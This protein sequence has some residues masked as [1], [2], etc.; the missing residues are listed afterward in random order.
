[1]GLMSWL[2]PSEAD[3]IAKAQ[4]MLDKRRWAGARAEVLDIDDPAAREIVA[5]AEHELALKNL[6]AAVAHCRSG[7]DDRARIHLK[8]ATEFAK[9]AHEEA[10]REAR[11][12]MRSIREG[13]RA[14]EEMRQ[15]SEAEMLL[16]VHPD[17]VSDDA[18]LQLPPGVSD[19]Q[20]E[21]LYARLSLIVDNYPKKLRK[22]MAELG[23]D[24]AQ[25]VLDLEDGKLDAALKVLL[26]LPDD[27]ALVRYERARAAHAMGD[28]AAAARA[29][30]GFEAIAGHHT[31]GR[32]HTG[33]LL[34][35]VLAES[36]KV[37]EAL[38]TL[39]RVRRKDRDAGGVLF[40]QL[41][42][43]RDRLPE[44]E[45]VLA[46]LVRKHPSE[47]PLY[48]LLARVRR[49]GGH[50]MAA[51][52]ALETGL[53]QSNCTPGRCG[54]KP[55]DLAAHR[56][57]ATLYLEDGIETERALELAGIAASLVKQQTWEDAYLATLVA[58]K[59]G[60]PEAGNM[61]LGLWAN[62]PEALQERFRTYLPAPA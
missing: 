48:T 6:E 37:D 13:F 42:E 17:F 12:E 51:M 53:G 9:G 34:A 59:Q 21:A 23:A 45:K 49:K 11:A 38:E 18:D 35:Q 40:A 10:F 62:T 43:A 28:P 15:R 44:A 29:L 3:R 5:A 20:A 54:Y 47:V 30:K 27:K 26:E 60:A 25:A 33:V 41:L 50:R 52:Q 14:D 19:D 1:M 32:I 24:F 22:E 61:V 56:M 36:G 7:D 2:F 16:E 4:K 31:I 46:E 39:T 57:L 58:H 8:M 55:P